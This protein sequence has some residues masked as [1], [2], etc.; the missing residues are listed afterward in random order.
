MIVLE[1]KKS[2]LMSS[3]GSITHTIAQLRVPAQCLTDL[4]RMMTTR[5]L[6]SSSRELGNGSPAG[7]A[8][9][10]ILMAK[11]V[12]EVKAVKNGKMKVQESGKMEVKESGKAKVKKNG[13]KV[14]GQKVTGKAKVNGNGKVE[15][16]A[17]MNGNVILTTFPKN[18]RS[19]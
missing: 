1:M 8:K 11:K 6:R 7:T 17:K 18:F 19:K 2:T 5:F 9:T 16:K 14:N 15:A 13:L 10:L 12:K 3:T 4:T